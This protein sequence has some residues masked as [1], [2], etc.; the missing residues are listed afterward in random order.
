MVDRSTSRRGQQNHLDDGRKA[1]DSDW[2]DGLGMGMK[3]GTR[4]ASTRDARSSGLAAM[5][6]LLAS[7]SLHCEPRSSPRDVSRHS[8][9]PAEA[10][11]A[12]ASTKAPVE[13]SG[14]ATTSVIGAATAS[15]SATPDSQL[16]VDGGVIELGGWRVVLMGAGERCEVLAE[17]GAETQR[18]PSDLRG[19]CYFVKDARQRVRFESYADV[20]SS[21]AILMGNPVPPKERFDVKCGSEYRASALQGVVVRSTGP[22]L[23]RVM[24]FSRLCM[25]STLD[26]KSYSI[27]AHETP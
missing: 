2:L 13:P 20:K 22:K 11:G 4:L 7:I 26:E 1:G 17:R 12:A 25:D 18:L 16:S 8:N 23:T 14:S 5:A 15:P 19:P 3:Y 9:A 6:F 21:V 10:P 27:F 24:P